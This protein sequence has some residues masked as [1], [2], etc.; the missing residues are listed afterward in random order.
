MR[1]LLYAATAITA[2][3]CC[4]EA[5]ASLISVGACIASATCSATNSSGATLV[6][7]S[8]TGGLAFSGVPVGNF[9]IGGNATATVSTSRQR[10]LSLKQSI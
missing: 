7:T 9:T 1:N 8:G 10:T 2:L 3:I 6:T 4:S 5:D